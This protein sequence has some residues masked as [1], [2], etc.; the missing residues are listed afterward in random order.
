MCCPPACILGYSLY[1][2]LS[3]VFSRRFEQFL[4]IFRAIRQR[5]DDGTIEETEFEKLVNA[6]A[7]TSASTTK[8]YSKEE[9]EAHLETLSGQGKVMKSE[10]TIYIID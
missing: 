3:F 8:P 10:G 4:S 2:F 1:I 9:V 7:E 6:Q 5:I